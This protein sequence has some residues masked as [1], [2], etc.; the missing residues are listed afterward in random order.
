MGDATNRSHQSWNNDNSR[1]QATTVPSRRTNQAKAGPPTRPDGTEPN[2]LRL[3]FAELQIA[4]AG[5]SC[6]GL[7]PSDELIANL[8]PNIMASP[9]IEGLLRVLMYALCRIDQQGIH[10]IKLQR[11]VCWCHQRMTNAKIPRERYQYNGGVRPEATEEMADDVPDWSQQNQ[12][13]MDVPQVI[14]RIAGQSTS[15]SEDLSSTHENNYS[16]SEMTF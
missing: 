12:N 4:F 6:P 1:Q 3:T 2:P 13:P 10:I 16:A 5:G 7:R 9:T 8:P 11:E 14:G 15:S